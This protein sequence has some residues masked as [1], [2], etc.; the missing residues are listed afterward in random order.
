MPAAR[1][2]SY[3]HGAFV[4]DPGYNGSTTN[5]SLLKS[6]RF[7]VACFDGHC[8]TITAY[9]GMDVSRWVPIGTTL[10]SEV[11]PEALSISE[12]YPN[13]NVNGLVI[14]R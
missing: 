2:W 5:V 13:N 14:N 10:S 9:Q 11:D 1:V 3:R 12:F 4:T 7:N 6:M 8:E